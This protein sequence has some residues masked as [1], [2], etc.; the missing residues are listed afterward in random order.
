M[1]IPEIYQY[2]LDLKIDKTLIVGNHEFAWSWGLE[3]NSLFLQYPPSN[4]LKRWKESGLNQTVLEAAERKQGNH[5]RTTTEQIKDKTMFYSHYL[6]AWSTSLYSEDCDRL[7]TGL[8]K[9]GFNK[10]KKQNWWVWWK[11]HDHL[12]Q[13]ISIG[14]NDD[15]YKTQIQEEDTPTTL[16][17]ERRHIISVPA[18][19]ERVYATLETTTMK[20][21]VK[22]VQ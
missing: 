9:D 13:V 7:S 2:L 19:V 5:A 8:I 11:G 16:R 14:I 20:Y 3:I 10:M 18:F 22:R 4:Y 21:D 15:P 12:N 17:E 6:T 1:D